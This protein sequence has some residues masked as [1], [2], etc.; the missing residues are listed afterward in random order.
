MGEFFSWS[1]VWEN[2]PKV[3]AK[4]PVTLE[5]VI[6]SFA[7]G[8][9][10]GCVIALLKIHKVPVFSQLGSIYISYIRGTPILVQLF[11]TYY[12]IPQVLSSV[13]HINVNTW[14]KMIYVFIAYGLNQ[15]GFLAE[16]I[17]GSITS[18]DASQ[19]E[20]GYSVGLTEMQTFVR[21]V[22]P[23][24]TRIA[25]PSMGTTFITLFR[26]TALAYM[27]GVI[28]IM[29][30]AKNIG[31]TSFHTLEGYVDAAL[32]FI[33]VSI[34]LEQLFNFLNRRLDYEKS[35]KIRHPKEAVAG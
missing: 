17:R 24:A 7:I 33:V 21:I 26:S 16:I 13:F 3:L 4:F 30:K 6:G 25:L 22:L 14:D 27:L 11:V 2:F 19:T 12:G 9:L 28:D 20:A 10:L 15:A 18:V 31:V 34:I 35:H 23:Q 1:T 32:I 5:I 29:G 8:L